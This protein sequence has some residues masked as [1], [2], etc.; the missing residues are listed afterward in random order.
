MQ[1]VNELQAAGGV[2]VWCW[3]CELN[4]NIFPP[5]GMWLVL[6]LGC[7]PLQYLQQSRD[8][9]HNNLLVLAFNIKY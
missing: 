6:V 8:I 7:G 1:G 5:S 3:C 9:K 4:P 2:L